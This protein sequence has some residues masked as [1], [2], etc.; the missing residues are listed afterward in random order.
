MKYLAY[1]LIVGVCVGLT[2][3]NFKIEVYLVT[4]TYDYQR[5][6]HKIYLRKD[7]AQKYIDMFKAHHSYNLE[8]MEI[9]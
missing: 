7:K 4:S 8:K 9:E 1:L 6:V 2:V 3:D 5:V